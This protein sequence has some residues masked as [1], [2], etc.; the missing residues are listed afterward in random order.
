MLPFE[1]CSCSVSENRSCYCV[2]FSFG[3]AVQQEGSQFPDQESNPQPLQ[4][5]CRVV[6][7]GLPEKCLHACVPS[8]FGHGSLFVTPWTVAHQLPLSMGFSRQEYWSGLSSPSLG[9]FLTKGWNLHLLGALAA[10]FFP[11]SAFL[12][13]TFYLMWHLIYTFSLLLLRLYSFICWRR[14]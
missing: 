14:Q 10:G 1:S 13:E 5:K 7:I 9:I 4:W 8:C 2:F 6:A 12:L 11:T 3:C